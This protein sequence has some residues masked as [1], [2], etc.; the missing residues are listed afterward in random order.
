M[1]PTLESPDV[2][3]EV[4]GSA[5]VVRPGSWKLVEG[6]G[7]TLA[8]PVDPS[9]FGVLLIEGMAWPGAGEGGRECA[10]DA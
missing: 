5:G 9:A 7:M 2:L 3:A 8:E 10:V 6:V 4:L 1:V